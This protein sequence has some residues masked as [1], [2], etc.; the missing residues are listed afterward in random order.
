MKHL[1]WT[2]IATMLGLVALLALIWWLIH[3]FSSPEQ[4]C[5]VRVTDAKLATRPILDCTAIVRDLIHWQGWW[6]SALIAVL[7]IAFLTIVA[8]DRNA[9]IKAKAGSA[10]LEVGSDKAAGAAEA[11]GAAV[12]K[13]AEIAGATP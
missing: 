10:E 9:T 8:V 7:G 12:D 2:S 13:A 4:W 11:A 6:G 3:I 5:G 1:S